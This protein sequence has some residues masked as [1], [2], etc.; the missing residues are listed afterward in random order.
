MTR[1]PNSAIQLFATM[2]RDEH[3]HA[4]RRAA[5]TATPAPA[6]LTLGAAV[7]YL[8]RMDDD[9]VR[10]VTRVPAPSFRAAFAAAVTAHGRDADLDV[11][12]EHYPTCHWLVRAGYTEDGE[13]IRD[14]AADV[15]FTDTGWSCQAGHEHVTA[16]VRHAQ[17]WDYAADAEEAALL[18]KHGTDAVHISGGSI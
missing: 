1:I 16:E 12:T 5:A 13:V 4:T 9:D 18:R 3:A 14:C 15:T 17:G 2:Q 8:S 6:A 10:T 7:N 11:L